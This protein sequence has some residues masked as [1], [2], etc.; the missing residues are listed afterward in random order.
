MLWRST[1]PRNPLFLA[2]ISSKLRSLATPILL[3]LVCFVVYNANLRQIGAGDTLSARYL[4]LILWRHGTLE[5]SSTNARLV[6]HGH[7]Q[8]VGWN[9]PIDGEAKVAYFEPWAYWIART[10]EH[11]RASLYPVVAPVLVAPLYAPAV[12]WLNEHGWGQPQVGWVAEW[13]EKISASIIASI[14]SVLMY[15]VLRRDCGR[16][17]IPLTLAFAFGTNTWMISSQA[18]WQHGTAELLIALALLL[19]VGKV[20]PWRTA[21]LGAAC[22]LMTANRPPDG[23]IAVA[24]GIFTLWNQRRGALWLVVGGIVPLA[25][26]LYYNIHFIGNLN[27]AYGLESGRGFYQ[28]GLAGVAGLLVSPSRGLLIFSPFLVFL[29]LGLMQRLRTPHTKVLAI[30]LSLAALTQFAFYSQ[31]DWRA[32][33]CW[34]PRWLTDM[35]PILV[36][37]LAPAPLVLRPFAR[38]VLVTTMAVSIAVQAIGA[39]WY[40]GLSEERIWAE[41]HQSM[42]GAW[43]YKNI[44]FIKELRQPPACGE[45]LDN[46]LGSLDRVGPTLMVAGT[47]EI[48]EL[49]PNTVLEGWALAGGRTP[50]Q[51]LVLIDGIAVG[52]TMEFLPRADVNAAMHTDALSGWRVY[53]N[54]R[55]VRP[56]KRVLQLALR[57]QPRSDVRILGEWRVFVVA[58]D[59]ATEIAATPQKP[60][61]LA[62]LGAMAERASS[63]LRSR[64]NE[65]GYWLTTYTKRLRYEDPQPE[66]NTY[67]TSMLVDLLSPIA[68]QRGLSE[69]MDRAKRH[70]AAQIESNGLVRYHG[71]P[72]GPIIGHLGHAITPDSDDTALAW[73]I[74]GP[75]KND[76]R[77]EP[78]LKELARYRDKRGLYRTWLAP[79]DKYQG[80]D[81]GRDP[82]PTDLT[83]QMHIYLMLRQLDPPAAEK[84]A[85]AMQRSFVE[86]DVWVY[87]AKAPLVPYLRCAELRQLGCD[88]PLPIERLA[89]TPE[90]QEVWS[91][92]VRLFVAILESPQDANLRQAIR[93]LL[94]RIGDG[95]F[96]QLRQS[97][98]MLYHND[99]SATVK[100]FYWS[101]DSGYALWLRLYE[102]TVENPT[103]PRP[104]P[105]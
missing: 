55:G 83:I 13:M 3:G 5:I 1:F 78:M 20:S 60:A 18:L 59:P 49:G 98:P 38:G 11:E 15:L 65:Q 95:D 105:P 82:N 74:A 31:F 12:L 72:D 86:E 10:L 47:R 101:E 37:L 6:A 103:S 61:T 44:P 45:L 23:V 89:L 16:W 90:G 99:M 80:L 24:F 17:S 52:T 35:L 92:A 69:A 26:H 64:Q 19:A 94:V 87:Y 22:V 41:G 39:F 102:A 77:L 50:A 28:P 62:D 88:I 2:S 7:S 8:T 76:P 51:L 58:P 73:R 54:T 66:M 40:T 30:A 70:L 56:G 104:S 25:A 68:S 75:G 4:P 33:A 79:R 21:L 57:I 93:Q 84:L 53:A 46:A 81:P 71:L 27:G 36:W 29:P 14:A 85:R 97:P 34:G 96:A 63:L 9:R 91:E 100:R 42:K 32:G 48:P 67:L 43:D